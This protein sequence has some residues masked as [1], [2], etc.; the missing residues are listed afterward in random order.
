MWLIVLIGIAAFLVLAVLL[1]VGIYFFSRMNADDPT[2]KTVDDPT[3]GQSAPVQSP[4]AT[5]TQ[6][7]SAEAADPGAA[8]VSVGD[9]VSQ[10]SGAELASIP[11]EEPHYGQVY[12]QE[13][14]DDDSYPGVDTLDERAQNFCLSGAEGALDMSKLGDDYQ[15]GYIIPDGEHWND[16]SQ[17]YLTC[18]VTRI[19]EKD[20]D[21]NLLPTS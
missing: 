7:P 8:S 5:S 1:T 18:F 11:C 19:D 13:F 4:G 17:R 10:P 12:A 16:E 6:Q 14:L 20:F 15:A 9:C 2:V 3:S 21:E